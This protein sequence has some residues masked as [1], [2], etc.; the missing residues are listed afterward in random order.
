MASVRPLI[1]PNFDFIVGLPLGK[2]LTYQ[3]RG[4]V[5]VTRMGNNARILLQVEWLSYLR[6][7]PCIWT[8]KRI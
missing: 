6:P 4:H 7:S 1:K 8:G 5:K 3:N 2:I